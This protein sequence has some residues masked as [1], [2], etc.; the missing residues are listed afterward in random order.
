[1]T[2][3]ATIEGI[4]G[5]SDSQ[6]SSFRNWLDGLLHSET[7][8]IIFTKVDGTERTMLATKKSSLISKAMELRLVKEQADT[9]SAVKVARQRK[10]PDSK[11]NITVWDV[12]K[13]GWR[14]IKVKNIQNILTLILKYD[15]QPA[16]PFFDLDIFN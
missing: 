13:E 12:D 6:W 3:I 14:T 8:E 16:K 9:A 7:I 2:D 10:A 11:F 5:W 15:Y 1:M 4:D